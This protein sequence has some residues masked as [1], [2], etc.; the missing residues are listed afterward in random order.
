MTMRHTQLTDELQERASLYAAGAMTDSEQREYVRHLEEDQCAVCRAEVDELQSAVS[1]LAFGVPTSTPSP[2]VKERL[3]EQARRAGPVREQ[4][5]AAMPWLNWLTGAVA[6]ASLGLAL[7]VTQTNNQLRRQ[8]D[9]LTSRI[10]QLEVE[11]AGQRNEIATLTSAG[12]KVVDLAGQ[13]NNVQASG[14]IFWNQGQKRWRFYVRGLPPAPADKDYQ[15]W[16]VPKAGNPVSAKV[17]D[18]DSNGSFE[19]EIE[20]PDN[21]GELKAAAVTTEPAGGL[22]LPSGAFALLGAL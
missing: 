4:K 3:M 2:A 21:A 10:A 16:F 8:T 11:L 18:T 5:R 20:V 12:V 15:L 9:Q 1:L 22:Q 17:F 13:G 7:I 6:V 19:V 14:R